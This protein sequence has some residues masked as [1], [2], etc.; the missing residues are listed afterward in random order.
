MKFIYI[1][2]F[3]SVIVL[4]TFGA[5][6]PAADITTRLQQSNDQ[7]IQRTNN[8][9]NNDLKKEEIELNKR[10]ISESQ[11]NQLHGRDKSIDKTDDELLQTAETHIFLPVLIQHHK[12]Y[13]LISSKS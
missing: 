8:N 11:L 3:L 13:P 12:K 10:H 7:I 4:Q 1:L 5:R 6:I 9:N 2:P